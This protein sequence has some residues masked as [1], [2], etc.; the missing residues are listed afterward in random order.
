MQK[1]IIWI[2]LLLFTGCSV[3][4]WTAKIEMQHIPHTYSEEDFLCPWDEYPDPEAIYQW[5]L[6]EYHIPAFHLKVQSV[7]N[8]CWENSDHEIFLHWDKNP[9]YYLSGNRVVDAN[10]KSLPK[11]DFPYEDW[12]PY[13]QE[14]LEYVPYGKPLNIEAFIQEEWLQ[15]EELKSLNNHYLFSRQDIRSIIDTNDLNT[16]FILKNGYDYYYIWKPFPFTATGPADD[17][18][19]GKIIPFYNGSK[20]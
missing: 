16:I 19:F 14:Y 17:S 12:D 13:T 11:E 4:S 10:F 3:N 6:T 8:R 1:Y 2:A 5:K 20:K 7:R 15:K 9:A 18:I